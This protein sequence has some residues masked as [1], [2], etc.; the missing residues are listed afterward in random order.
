[1][2]FKGK[3]RDQEILPITVTLFISTNKVKKQ[4]PLSLG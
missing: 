4:K 2:Q 3:A 1:M